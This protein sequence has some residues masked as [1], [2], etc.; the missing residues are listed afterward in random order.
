[1][2]QVAEE[3]RNLLLELHPMFANAELPEASERHV[4]KA[5]WHLDRAI[6]KALWPIT[7]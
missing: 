6:Q 4:G 3:C 5:L 2:K 1:L 7:H